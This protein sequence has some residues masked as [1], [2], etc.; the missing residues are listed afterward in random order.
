MYFVLDHNTF[1]P[2]SDRLIENIIE[3]KSSIRRPS[4]QSADIREFVRSYNPQD[5]KANVVF[6]S[7]AAMEQQHSLDVIFQTIH[8]IKAHPKTKQLF[9]WCSVKNIKDSRLVP[10]VEHMADVVVTLMDKKTLT[11]LVKRSSGSVTRKVG[12]N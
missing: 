11:I 9:V 1:E 2:V 5:E 10:F 8:T 3:N 7:L 12:K 6:S 4:N